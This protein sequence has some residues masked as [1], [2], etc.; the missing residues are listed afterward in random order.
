MITLIMGR[1]MNGLRPR[2]T[3]PKP[4]NTFSNIKQ[5]IV[6]DLFRPTYMSCT[7]TPTISSL[8]GIVDGLGHIPNSP[9]TTN[10]IS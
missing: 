3:Y 9:I 7:V 6:V 4:I 5:G 1:R 8:G 2:Y 10:G